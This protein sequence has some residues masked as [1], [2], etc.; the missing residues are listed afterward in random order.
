VAGIILV[1][2]WVRTEAGEAKVMLR[3]YYGKRL[4]EAQFWKK[5]LAGGVAVGRTVREVARAAGRTV[6]GGTAPKSTTLPDRMAAAVAT[7]RVPFALVLSARDYVAREFENEL[8]RPGWRQ[9][10][11]GGT[12]VGLERLQDADHT[13]S[14]STA[15]QALEALT[16]TLVAQVASMQSGDR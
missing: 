7:G 6:G 5:L 2:P 16:V 14:N 15:R 10:V 13:F 12:C 4:F 9:L 3:H 11:E 1:N 8:A